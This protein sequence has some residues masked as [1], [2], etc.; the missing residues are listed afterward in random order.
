MRSS[1]LFAAVGTAPD[2]RLQTQ[3]GRP[4]RDGLTATPMTSLLLHLLHEVSGRAEDHEVACFK[5]DALLKP[6]YVHAQQGQIQEQQSL[7]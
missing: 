7:K 2:G 5:T 6:Q 1:V 3:Q 4:R